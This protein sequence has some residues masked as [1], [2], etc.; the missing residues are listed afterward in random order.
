MTESKKR[1][2]YDVE[3]NTFPNIS[4]EMDKRA[5]QA[6][7]AT[8]QAIGCDLLVD[9][10]GKPDY[11]KTMRRSEMAQ[12]VQDSNYMESYG[13]D[14]EAANYVIWVSRY[15]PTYHKKL[16]KKAFPFAIYGW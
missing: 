13:E 5:C 6:M 15:H 11:R 10:N 2:M 14:F 8:W 16:I 1:S 4:E 12:I 3:P 9:D 7:N